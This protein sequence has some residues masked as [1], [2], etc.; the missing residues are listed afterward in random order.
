MPYNRPIPDDK[1]RDKASKGLV[2][3]LVQAEKMM[4][5]ALVLPSA[6]LIGWLGGMWLDKR[7]HQSW[8][9]LAGFILGSISGL[10]SAIRMAMAGAADPKSEDKNGN[11]T[12]KGSPGGEP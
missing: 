3:G 10:A 12:K 11:G 2:E 4:Q 5:I 1:P 7:L 8:I 6:V 9:T